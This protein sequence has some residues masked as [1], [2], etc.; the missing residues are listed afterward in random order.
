MWNT[1]IAKQAYKK[2]DTNM[3]GL[4]ETPDEDVVTNKLAEN[5]IHDLDEKGVLAREAHAE[6]NRK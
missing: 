5:K 6:S 2:L 1:Y 4:L 3:W